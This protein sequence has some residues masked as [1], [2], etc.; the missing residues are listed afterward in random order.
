VHGTFRALPESRQADGPTGR[1]AERPRG[2]AR[3]RRAIEQAFRQSTLSPQPA[4]DPRHHPLIALV[5]VSE[6][7]QQAM[8]RQHAKL[9]RL[10]V[11]RS[12]GLP[13]GDAAS[14]HD[15]AQV[16][17]TC[18]TETR[19]SEPR[20]GPGRCRIFGA[21]ASLA[22]ALGTQAKAGRPRVVCPVREHIGGKGITGWKTEYVGRMVLAQV[23]EVQRP[24]A[25]VAHE[26][27]ADSAAGPRR[28]HTRQ[29]A[30]E[31]AGRDRAPTL[32]GHDDG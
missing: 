24:H 19:G 31:A 27:D 21:P 14:D 2:H 16:G 10:V 3:A 26:R 30:G 4:L 28:R 22:E 7:V 32:I 11:A 23:P 6:Q 9:G 1:R 8:Q 12:A 18:R 29:P 15:I 17:P 5:I 25:C 20:A 13:A